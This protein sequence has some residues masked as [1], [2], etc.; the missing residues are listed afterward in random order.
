MMT[1]S[2][3]KTPRGSSTI[4]LPIR[5]ENYEVVVQDPEKFRAALDQAFGDMPELF[6]IAFAQGYILK[7][8]RMSLKLRMLLRRIACK[9]TAEAFTVR[10]SF[11]MPYMT[12]LTE[13]VEKAL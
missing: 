8:S 7:D 2:R 4:C 5:K 9:A 10:P 12:A 6:P 3:G 11:V 1:T 13:E